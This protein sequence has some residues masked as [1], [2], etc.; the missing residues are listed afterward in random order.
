[1]K[2]FICFRKAISLLLILGL[3]LAVAFSF[4]SCSSALGGT[5]APET[6]EELLLKISRECEEE[7]ETVAEYL[8]FWGFPEFSKTKLETLEKL[9]RRQFVEELPPPYEK[10]KET[11]KYFL[12]NYYEGNSLS[13]EENTDLLI[14]SFVETSGDKYSVYRT[15]EKYDDY[16]TDMSGSF[17][18]IGVTVRY[19]TE[20]SEILIEEVSAGGG[21]EEAGILP[22]DY[23]TKVNGESVADIGYEATVS[24]IKGAPNTSVDV[25][26]R[27]GNEEITFNIIRRT[28]VV[29]SVTYS[30]ENDVAYIKI[31]GFKSNTD[32]Q[33]KAAIDDALEQNVKGI[34]YDLRGNPGG[35]LD[36]VLEMLEYIAP[37]GTPLASFTNDYMDPVFSKTAHAVSLPTVVLCDGSTASAGELFTAGIRD[38]AAKGLF[39]ATL[40]GVKTYGKGIMQNTYLFSDESSITMTVAYYNPPSGINYH[41]VG[42]TPDVIVEDGEGD[43]QL[44]AA[45]IEIAK[46]IK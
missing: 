30:I 20:V 43:P 27:R 25:T 9:Y 11:G 1:M 19:N 14:H 39:D 10:A 37:K 35:Y 38:F 18:G 16:H 26:V 46:I 31:T 34:I 15:A 7:F 41:G 12:E 22:G 13:A 6:K 40:V 33:F 32:A 23:I 5:T 44:D 45:Y 4:T 21:A 24:N 8:D 3:S 17:V 36:T 28:I 42:I 29:K 2:K